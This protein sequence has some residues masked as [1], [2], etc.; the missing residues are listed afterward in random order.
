MQ[1][2]D[3]WKKTFPKLWSVRLALLSALAS[4]IETG[5]N[6]YATGTAPPLVVAACLVSV[7]AAIARIIAQPAV[8][9]NG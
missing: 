8:T 1:F 7:G 9:G 2:I 5:M 3:D 6:L 4:S